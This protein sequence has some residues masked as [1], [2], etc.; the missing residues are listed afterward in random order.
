MGGVQP[1]I[2]APPNT[3][4]QLE[5]AS[6][7]VGL[8]ATSKDG[9]ATTVRES[10]A[11][12]HA[13]TIAEDDEDVF[14]FGGGFDEPPAEDDPFG[15]GGGMDDPPVAAVSQPSMAA[16]PLDAN[17]SAGLSATGI[18]EDDD[19]FG[20]GGGL[21]DPPVATVPQASMHVQPPVLHQSAH[22]ATA[23]EEDDPFGFG[24]GL[25]D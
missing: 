19:P 8:A 3:R 1:K 22:S 10:S 9:T 24:G 25:D 11:Q 17:P 2:S 14:G 4:T 5:S 20:F 15:F 13:T 6:M 23:I 7:G 21:D 12:Q 16:R 18:E